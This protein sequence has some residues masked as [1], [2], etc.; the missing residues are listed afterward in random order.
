[1]APGLTAAR[2]RPAGRP[3]ASHADRALALLVSCGSRDEAERIAHALVDRRLARVPDAVA[4]WIE[5]SCDA[6]GDTD[7]PDRCDPAR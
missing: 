3:H 6:A 7:D 4:A 5:A 2:T 1:M